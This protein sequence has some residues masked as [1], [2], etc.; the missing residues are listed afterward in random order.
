MSDL[1]GP[2]AERGRDRELGGPGHE[3][4]VVHMP[5]DGEPGEVRTT[6]QAIR[7][8]AAASGYTARELV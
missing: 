2:R 4:R 1:H 3:L 6:D 8:A 7:Q 5:R